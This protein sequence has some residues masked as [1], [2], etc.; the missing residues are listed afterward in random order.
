MYITSI[1]RVFLPSCI[2]LCL[3]TQILPAASFGKFTYVDDGTSISIT[4]Y[5]S[6]ATGAVII[7]ATILGKPVTSIGI[8]AFF[9]CYRLKSITLPNSLTSI[10]DD[11]FMG[12]GFASIYIPSRVTSIGDDVFYACDALKTITVDARNPSY[13][14]VN[15]LLFNRQKTRFIHCPKAKTGSIKLPGTVITIGDFACFECWHLTS[16]TIPDGVI[17]IGNQAFRD[18]SGLT[19]LIL[20]KGVKSIGHGA[21]ESCSSLTSLVIPDRLTTIE[22]GAFNTCYGLTSLTIPGSVTSI[23]DF[24]FANCEGLTRIT[25]PKGVISIGFDAFNF[26]TG[27]KEAIFLGD[28]PSLGEAAFDDCDSDF[29]IYYLEG[30]NRFSSPKWHGYPAVEVS[31]APDIAIQQPI[32]SDLVDGAAK[33]SFGSAKVGITGISKSFTIKNTGTGRLNGLAVNIIGSDAGDFRVT[34]PAKTS[35]APDASTTV[36]VT[37]KPSAS[38]TRSAGIHFKSND[39]DED[40]F[41]INISGLGV[42]P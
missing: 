25:L 16:V 13:S 20:P 18:C 42:A 28:A 37:F 17:S 10:G 40:P 21:F 36:K 39:A 27:L 22:A 8:R 3:I 31:S 6:D 30:K 41:D 32:G 29:A 19:R 34:A 4:G 26:C 12:C 1:L 24:A 5:P 14:S 35:L 11:A 23:G 7:P 33:R 9:D 2:T 38:G 15:G